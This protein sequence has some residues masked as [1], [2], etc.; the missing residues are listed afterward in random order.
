MNKIYEKGK[1]SIA[2]NKAPDTKR[3]GVMLI[4]QPVGVRVV[5]KKG[6]VCISQV[7]ISF[8][9]GLDTLLINWWISR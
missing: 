5:A 3:F 6:T 8:G 2:V 7:E 1:F 4:I 9:F